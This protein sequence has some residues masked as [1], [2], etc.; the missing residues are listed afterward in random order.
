MT[1]EQVIQ[2]FLVT[3][4]VTAVLAILTMEDCHRHSMEQE[5][6]TG[7]KECLSFDKPLPLCQKAYGMEE[8]DFY[9]APDRP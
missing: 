7:Y 9:K 4:L 6:V 5:R 2:Y 8:V 3:A 1:L